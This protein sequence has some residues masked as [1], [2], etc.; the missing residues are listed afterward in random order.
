MKALKTY[1]P[2]LKSTGNR[3][4]VTALFRHPTEQN[5][6]SDISQ[7]DSSSSNTRKR[8]YGD[9]HKIDITNEIVKQIVCKNETPKA[10]G[11]SILSNL[12]EALGLWSQRMIKLLKN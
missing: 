4:V 10:N 5:S 8:S 1:I 3:G 6:E 12:A 2:R 9:G 7:Q 11:P